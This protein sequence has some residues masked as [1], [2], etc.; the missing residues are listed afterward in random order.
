MHKVISAA[1]TAGRHLYE[2]EA[3]ALFGD[4]GIPAPNCCLAKSEAEALDAAQAIG[5]P[6]VLK[7]VSPDILHKSDAGGVKVNISGPDSLTAAYAEILSSVKAYNP[8]ARIE[9]ILVCQ[10]LKPGV[11]TII[12]MTRDASFGPALMFGLGGIFVEVLKDVSFRVLPISKADALAMIG[13]IKGYPL[14][15]GI[16]GKE[17]QD[18]EALAGLLLKVGDM[19]RDNPEIKE[20]DINPCFVYSQGVLPADARVML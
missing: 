6:V 13:E 16:R 4:Y 19:I 20:L 11:E 1:K 7:I 8:A 5:Y 17:P 10:M 3:W 9:G 14:L 15:Q 12:G 2:H 18:V